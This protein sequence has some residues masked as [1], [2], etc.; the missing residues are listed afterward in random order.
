MGP[1]ARLQ[2]TG[3]S[4]AAEQGLGHP[5]GP[6]LTQSLLCPGS[7]CPS[8]ASILSSIPG[9]WPGQPHLA[10]IPGEGFSQACRQFSHPSG[11]PH[12]SPPL[13]CHP[14]LHGGDPGLQV[15]AGLSGPG[16]RDWP[17]GDCS[18]YI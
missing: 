18:P 11:Q 8:P 17:P 1:A 3:P 15:T 7:L 6:G 14:G 13:A 16:A 4:E 5:S 10:S 2:N 12:T 9:S